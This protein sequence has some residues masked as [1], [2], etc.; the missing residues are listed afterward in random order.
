MDDHDHDHDH[1]AEKTEEHGVEAQHQHQ[2]N[3]ALAE[4]KG[5]FLGCLEDVRRLEGSAKVLHYRETN[6]KTVTPRRG[7]QGSNQYPTPGSMPR[8][9]AW[10]SSEGLKLPSSRR[11]WCP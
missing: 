5:L 9:P 2:G 7:Q 1:T 4:F 11:Q 10:G 8:L 6:S 3:E